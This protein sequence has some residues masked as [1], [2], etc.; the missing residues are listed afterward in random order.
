VSGW[1]VRLA[2]V[3]AREDAND[4]RLESASRTFAIEDSLGYLLNRSARLMAHELAERLRPA[5]V[6]IGQWP[7]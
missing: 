2:G 4:S 6:A 1:S 7:V 3:V 5:G